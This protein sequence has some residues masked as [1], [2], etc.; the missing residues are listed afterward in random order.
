MKPT[1][2]IFSALLVSSIT[3]P[4]SAGHPP[5]A[6]P[7]AAPGSSRQVLLAVDDVSLPLRKNTCLYLSKPTVRPDPVLTP[8][9]PESQS[10][11]NLAAHFYGTVIQDGEKFRMWY[12]ACHRGMNPDWPARKRQ[13]VVK[14][15]SWL[16]GVKD[17]Y[18]VVQ[19]PLCYAESNDGLTWSKPELGQVLFKGTRANNALDLPHTVVSG[20]AVIKDESDPDAARRYKMIYQFFPDQTAPV[21]PEYGTSPSIA[22][23]VSPD[24]LRWTVTAVPFV[25]QFVEHC[26]F[27]RHGGA[28]IV[29]S[30]VFPGKTWAGVFTEGGAAGGRSG[31]AHV[32]YDFDR[33]PALWQW[34]FALP[35]PADRATRGTF[36]DQP[37]Q[38]QVHLGVGAASFGN[39]CV[40]VYGLW[41]DRKDFAEIT[42][43]LGL[44][45]SNDGIHFR[46]PSATPGR[47]FIH[48]EDSPATPASGRAFNTILC[49]GNGI[50][51]VG[52]ETRIYHGRW[53]NV[54]QKAEDVANDYRAEVALA[55]LPRDRWGAL[56]LNPGSKEGT[57]G[58]GVVELP[59]GDF[60]IRL[61]ADDAQSMRVE[62]TDARFKPLEGYSGQD[63]G[64]PQTNGGLDCVVRWPKASLASLSGK[65]V[66]IMVHF[67][68]RENGSPRLFAI[69]VHPSVERP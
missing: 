27:L 67:S 41:H 26:S 54:G 23:A 5:V 22:C 7:G 2:A 58:S 37:N 8:S 64:R 18:E 30:Q 16:I 62:L 38:P 14:K 17:G 11:D 65:E 51:N 39:V 32:T 1:T 12:Y 19:G 52:D 46:E 57:V 44:V 69:Y 43:D 10:P 56:A 42:C 61:N 59:A 9:S 21:I 68:S 36:R 6:K 25:N 66:R 53:R 13:Q 63:S 40:G 24:G 60:E 29:H 45:V 50:L 31:V 28:Y 35:E 4:D 20:A 3:A 47:P 49:Q 48:R 55:T 15:P 33:W 34:A